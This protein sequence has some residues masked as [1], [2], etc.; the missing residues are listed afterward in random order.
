M[1]A[2]KIGNLLT[3]SLANGQ[4]KLLSQLIVKKNH[5]FDFMTASKK[6]EVI[7]LSEKNCQNLYIINKY[8][9][10]SEETEEELKQFW[11]AGHLNKE[12]VVSISSPAIHQ[13]VCT[14]GENSTMRLWSFKGKERKI[15]FEEKMMNQPTQL[16]MHPCGLL[17]AINYAN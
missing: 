6:G 1:V 14:L 8:S 13:R 17:V 9:L 5:S 16:A 2:T 10:N 3:Y 4:M 7:L 11:G 12:S 15:I